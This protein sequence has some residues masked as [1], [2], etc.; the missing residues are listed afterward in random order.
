M[1]HVLVTCPRDLLCV[2]GATVTTRPQLR[3]PEPP[4]E[5]AVMKLGGVV[6]KRRGRLAVQLPDPVDAVIAIRALGDALPDY[7]V[8]IG[9]VALSAEAVEMLSVDESPTRDA[10]AW[11][12]ASVSP[13]FERERVELDRGLGAVR[14][15]A[16]LEQAPLADEIVEQRVPASGLVLWR[17]DTGALVHVEREPFVVG[18][19]EGC[20]YVI[21]GITMARRHVQFERASDGG[22]LVRDLASPSGFYI[23]GH[24][25]GDQ[26]DLQAGMVIQFAKPFAFVVLA[27][28]D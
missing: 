2:I 9:A 23:D 11:L 21:D 7:N 25:G 14:H 17:A 10:W 20:D 27:T 6:T 28:N 26:F 13:A 18:R 19:Q 22:W 1:T 24:R 5:A 12:R 3:D 8:D 15:F 16:E 4:I